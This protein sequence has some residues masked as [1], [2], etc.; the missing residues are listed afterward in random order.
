MAYKR[1][2][3][4]RNSTVLNN[5][6]KLVVGEEVARFS[7]GG[8]EAK[9]IDKLLFHKL[10]LDGKTILKFH[11]L[12]TGKNVNLEIYNFNERYKEHIP[13]TIT[14]MAKRMKFDK[15]TVSIPG[16]DLHKHMLKNGFE[17]NGGLDVNV[18]ELP[19]TLFQ[20]THIKYLNYSKKLK[21]VK[22]KPL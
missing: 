19:D 16:A 10:K 18:N 11:M 14:E 15:L 4:K 3:V 22:N 6:K 2:R 21:A 5:L 9:V 8:K 17:L 12:K 13:R 7:V 1:V 20:P